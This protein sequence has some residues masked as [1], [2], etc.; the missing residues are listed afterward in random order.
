[1]NFSEQIKHSK[2][3]EWFTE[4]ENVQIIVPYLLRG[5]QEDTLSI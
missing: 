3:D 2:T 4:K 1:M 5:V